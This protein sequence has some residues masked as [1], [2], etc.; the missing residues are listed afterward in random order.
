MHKGV[1]LM[2]F[3]ELYLLLACQS[4]SHHS[5]CSLPQMALDA[6]AG[7]SLEFLPAV[8]FFEQ[9]P[10]LQLLASLLVWASF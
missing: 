5:T 6:V 1:E 10:W 2:M 7:C 4:T 8:V 9:L 3:S